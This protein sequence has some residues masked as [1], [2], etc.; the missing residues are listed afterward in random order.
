MLR[1]GLILGLVATAKCVAAQES[2]MAIDSVILN[3]GRVV[4]PVAVNGRSDAERIGA[5]LERVPDIA[6]LPNGHARPGSVTV[7][8]ALDGVPGLDGWTL[9]ERRLIIL[10]WPRTI[11][12]PETRLLKV[13]THEMAHIALFDFFGG[14]QN[15]L[16]GW[17][18]EG[19]A[20]WASGG[21]SCEGHMRLEIE[22]RRRLGLG[23]S[24]PSVYDDDWKTLAG[25]IAYDVAASIVGFI[26]DRLELRTD[27]AIMLDNMAIHGWESGLEMTLGAKWE[28]LEA[29]WREE[30]EERAR[31]MPVY[32]ECAQRSG[33]VGS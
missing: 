12:W 16:P 1:I 14:R 9:V 23:L 8:L 26:T 15:V 20:E 22:V 28:V 31:L 19:F 6:G 21:L 18:E 17:F 11:V 3:R 4:Y 33:L 13:L 32:D 27:M 30:I 10:P 5:V 29:A 25:R 2:V 7:S 24:L